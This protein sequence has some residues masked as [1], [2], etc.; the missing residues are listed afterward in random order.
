M[1][2]ARQA[3][4]HIFHL[5]SSIYHFYIS[6][7]DGKWTMKNRYDL[8][9]QTFIAYNVAM[10][11]L[12]DFGSQTAHLIARRVR[13]MGVPVEIVEPEKAAEFVKKNNPEGIIFS[14]GPLSV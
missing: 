6:M 13:D 4:I 9:F 1:Y 8:E 14:G 10:I 3:E 12:V 5:S 2:S 7:L 11:V